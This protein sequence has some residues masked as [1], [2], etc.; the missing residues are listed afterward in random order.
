MPRNAHSE[1]VLSSLLRVLRAHTQMLTQGDMNAFFLMVGAFPVSSDSIES[2][3]NSVSGWNRSVVS[4]NAS[5][6]LIT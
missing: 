5:G 3:N 4:R 1:N 2:Q 6:A